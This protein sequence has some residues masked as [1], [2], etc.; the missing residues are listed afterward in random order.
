MNLQINLKISK[1]TSTE[2]H[3]F[4]STNKSYIFFLYFKYG[5]AVIYSLSDI[6]SY[7]SINKNFVK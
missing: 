6:I 3:A 4:S 1:Q 2:H 7:F 5:I